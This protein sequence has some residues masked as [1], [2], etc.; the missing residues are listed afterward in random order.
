[1]NRLFLIGLFLIGCSDSFEPES[2]CGDCGLDIYAVN[3]TEN[4]D[5]YK[6]E[7]EL[8]L[9]QTYTMLG[10]YKLSVVGLNMSVGI[11]YVSNIESMVK[12]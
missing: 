8:S 5:V 9:A 7:Y 4:G 3:L 1:M 10:C 11:T 6:M 12:I 2:D